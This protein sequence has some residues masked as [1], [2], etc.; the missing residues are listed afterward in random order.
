[1]NRHSAWQ[2]IIK[3]GNC[4]ACGPFN[5]RDFLSSIVMGDLPLMV[6]IKI[7]K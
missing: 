4:D 6:Y 7:E 5:S 3:V 2:M 1:M